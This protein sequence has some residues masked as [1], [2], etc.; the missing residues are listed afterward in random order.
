VLYV[1]LDGVLAQSLVSG[2]VKGTGSGYVSATAGTDYLI[3]TG[4]GS[5]L[6]GVVLLAGST[7]TGSLTL[8]AD[9]STSLG[10]ATKQ[11]V[12]SSVVQPATVVP[13]MDGTAVVGTSLL[14]ARQDHVHPSDTTRLAL[15]GGTMT[16][17]LVLS[18]DP[19][20]PLGAATKNYVD[21]QVSTGLATK[22]S[23]AGDTMTGSL[24]L[25]A[26]PSAPLGAATRQYVDNSISSIS[27]TVALT[28]DVTGSGT[29]SIATTVAKI[30]GALLGST[31]VTAGNILIAS[32]ASWVSRTVS[33]DITLS[34]AGAVGVTKI[35]GVGLG[36][37]TAT[38]G[39]ILMVGV[40]STW[41]STPITGDITLGV[42]GSVTVTKLVSVPLGSVVATSGNVL[43]GSGSSW[44]SNP[45]SGAGTLSSSGVLT[46]PALSNLATRS[47]GV[48]GTPVVNA[49]T[50]PIFLDRPYTCNNLTAA[51]GTAPSGGPVTV[52]IQ[53][54]TDGVSWTSL[55]SGSV[56][57]ASGSY[58]GTQGCTTSISANT[59]L[60]AQFTVVNGAANV[61]TT[62]YLKY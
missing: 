36:A 46:I 60:R 17:L 28:G 20:A 22:V 52:V 48:Q 4:S 25:N 47:F 24:T 37:T 2:L 12:D 21:G 59:L 9:P 19:S 5:Q 55:A 56:S 42:G 33:G 57:I 49:T 62:L 11:Y 43:I 35:N 23:K 16:G 1:G 38:L 6:T 15:V 50:P 54:S 58:A 10:A 53:T 31:V 8:H 61:V 14:Y 3:P 40:T 41:T 44:V 51:C 45:V 27:L 26:D 13:V 30:N 7:M 32:G 18:A 39:N 34:S 29:G